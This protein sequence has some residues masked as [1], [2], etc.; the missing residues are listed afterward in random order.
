MSDSLNLLKNLRRLEQGELFPPC[1]SFDQGFAAQLKMKKRTLPARFSADTPTRNITMINRS[2]SRS[3]SVRVFPVNEISVPSAARTAAF[4]MSPSQPTIPPNP[5]Q[6][7]SLLLDTEATRANNNSLYEAEQTQHALNRAQKVVPASFLKQYHLHEKLKYRALQK[8]F[9]LCSKLRKNC[10]HEALL[11][12]HRL[13]SELTILS[14]TRAAVAVSRI[15]RGHIGRMR[16]Q[17]LR[18]ANVMSGN[19][20]FISRNALVISKLQRWARRVIARCRRDHHRFMLRQAQ[21]QNYIQ[22]TAHSKTTLSTEQLDWINSRESFSDNPNHFFLTCKQYTVSEIAACR[23]IQSHLQIFLARA[24]RRYLRAQRHREKLQTRLEEPFQA[25]AVYFEHNGAA[26]EIQKW[27]HSLPCQ[28]SRNQKRKAEKLHKIQCAKAVLLQRFF[29]GY[30]T[31]KKTR[32]LRSIGARAML[33]KMK[34]ALMIQ[35]LFRRFRVR[36]RLTKAQLRKLD[37][38]KRKEMRR[39]EFRTGKYFRRRSFSFAKLKIKSLENINLMESSCSTIQRCWLRSK[40]RRNLMSFFT[41]VKHPS[42]LK[43]ARWMRSWI[44][45]LRMYKASIIIQKQWN[46]KLAS[47]H[48]KN[49]AAITLQS[50]YRKLKASKAVSQYQCAVYSATAQILNWSRRILASSLFRYKLSL[51][52]RLHEI[53]DSGRLLYKNS[54]R[55][56]IVDELWDATKKTKSAGTSEVHKLFAM[57][58]SNGT[59]DMSKTQKILRDCGGLIGINSTDITVQDIELIFTRV[60]S[61]GERKLDYVQFIDLLHELA[62]M[63]YIN[64]IPQDV[65]I[66]EIKFRFCRK[67]GRAALVCKLILDFIRKSVTFKNIERE[68]GNDSAISR[69]R[70]RTILSAFII[71]RIGR[72]YIARLKIADVKQKKADLIEYNRKFRARLTIQR[73]GRSYLGRRFLVKLAQQIYVKC[74]DPDMKVPFWFNPR[75]GS[76]SWTK[77]KLLGDLDCGE[78]VKLP[79]ETERFSLMCAECEVTGASHYCDECDKAMCVACVKLLHRTVAKQNH[80]QIPLQMC[81]ECEFQVPTRLCVSCGDT[82]C[83]TCYHHV[84][85]RGRLKLHTYHWLIKP[86]D[87]CGLKAGPWCMTNPELAFHIVSMCTACYMDLNGGDKPQNR[88][89]GVFLAHYSGPAI[90][91]YRKRRDDELY[92][93]RV[94]NENMERAFC[95]ANQRRLFAAMVIQRVYRG[96]VCRMSHSAFLSERRLF[97]QLRESESPKRQRILYKLCDYFGLAK[98]LASDTPKER[99]LKMYPYFLHPTIIDCFQGKWSIARQYLERLDRR[100]MAAA[101]D[102][103]AQGAIGSYISLFCASYKLWSAKKVLQ[104][105]ESTHQLRRKQYRDARSAGAIKDSRKKRLQKLAHNALQNVHHAKLTL[106][107]CEM[108][109]DEMSM[110]WEVFAGPRG[111]KRMIAERR[112]NGIILPFTVSLIKGCRYAKVSVAPPSNAQSAH[113]DGAISLTVDGAVYWQKYLQFGDTVQIGGS[114]FKV[115]SGDEFLSAYDASNEVQSEIIAMDIEE[116]SDGSDDGTDERNGKIFD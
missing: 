116:R 102:G 41:L 72:G 96:F 62:K 10:T 110:Q 37:I 92:R 76:S 112:R 113:G 40:K 63:K 21:I 32:I 50:L 22:S 14:V 28:I 104:K 47:I 58:S 11:Y 36:K 26:F 39:V 97:I 9:T 33:R 45:R 12:W 86:C 95:I 27:F 1:E 103:S 75:T 73:F 25:Q 38:I 5:L 106:D 88:V 111:I 44:W 57:N 78:T 67:L 53:K 105:T 16:A 100:K 2:N 109:F 108:N 98:S 91:L 35:S 18:D 34:A 60:K 61:T 107:D 20:D 81:V 94:Q 74:D 24:R 42:A 77:P 49:K 99:V 71:Q 70:R 101:K 51:S 7:Y 82:Y 66:D 23:V 6:R 48:S 79:S 85:R 83:D 19:D 87:F 8:M 68:L 46:R 4:A 93:L 115:I 55:C 89:N 13:A 84:H 69:G 114:F 17:R 54:V 65:N 80:T 90:D 59:I 31:R 43:I 56:T 3:E 15:I 52:R 29:R 30:M 64:K